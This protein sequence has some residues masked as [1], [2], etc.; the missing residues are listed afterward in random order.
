MLEIYRM[1][2]QHDW[3]HVMADDRRVCLSG[4]REESKLKS[5]AAK[6]PERKA[7]FDAYHNY[8]WKGGEKPSKPLF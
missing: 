8:V 3:Y 7:L 4:E 6:S 5:I 2:E 1:L